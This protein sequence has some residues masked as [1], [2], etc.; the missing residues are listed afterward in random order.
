[1]LVYNKVLRQYTKGQ[2]T[3]L[4]W[5]GD[6][7]R[8]ATGRSFPY[9]F[10][11]VQRG[12]RT[13][14]QRRWD[15]KAAIAAI[16]ADGNG[17]FRTAEAHWGHMILDEA[18]DFEADAH[19][20]LFAVQQIGFAEIHPREK[21]SLMILA[22]ENQRLTDQNTTLEEIRAAYIMEDDDTYRLT[23]NYRNSREI[24]EFARTFYVGL[25]TG[26]PELPSSR[27]EKPRIVRTSKLNQAVD[28]IARYAQAHEDEEIAVLVYYNAT[29]KRFYNKLHHR[30]EDS[31][32]RVQTYS[33]QDKDTDGSDLRFDAGGV[34]TV[35]CF[36]SAKGLEFDAVFLPELQSFPTTAGRRDE[37][38]MTLYVM[39]SRAR[40]TLHLMLSDSD[41]EAD[42]W[43]LLPSD[44]D[45]YI[46]E[47]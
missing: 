18:Q 22:D 43:K 45:L 24:A 9:T 37:A 41:G 36:A 40:R 4:K 1:M 32:I 33:S 39:T 47:E 20:F 11:L 10:E 25:S 16:R 31:T 27:G 35:L 17:L 21:P 5:L 23:R 8:R 13:W 26:Q 29:R 3:F 38:R 42:V 46:L 6:W 7:W 2:Q 30:F 12:K 28:K 34:I 14:R 15:Y 44:S 19:R